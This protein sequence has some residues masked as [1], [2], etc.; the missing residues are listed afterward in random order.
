VNTNTL[1]VGWQVGLSQDAD[2]PLVWDETDRPLVAE[3]VAELLGLPVAEV[4]PLVEPEDAS[5]GLWQVPLTPERLAEAPTEWVVS[6][7]GTPVFV[8]CALP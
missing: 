3:A 5:L 1:S 6:A 4:L 8:E 7:N 2:G